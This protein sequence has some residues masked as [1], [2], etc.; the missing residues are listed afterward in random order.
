MQGTSLEK[1]MIGKIMTYRE[2]FENIIKT[3]GEDLAPPG[4]GGHSQP[5][6][7]FHP[8][9]HTP[10]PA[11]IMAGHCSMLLVQPGL[12]AHAVD[13]KPQMWRNERVIGGVV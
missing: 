1:D 10:L 7:T 9:V 5:P 4:T 2:Q 12:G 3:Q 8:T 6:V 13:K 11:C